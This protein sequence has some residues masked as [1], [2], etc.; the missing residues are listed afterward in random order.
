MRRILHI[1][2]LLSLVFVSCKKEPI[3]ELVDEQNGIETSSPKF[4]LKGLLGTDSVNI[5]SKGDYYMFS[6]YDFDVTNNH[7]V[8][9]GELKQTNCTSCGIGVTIK[10]N[11]YIASQA[12]A[13][14][15]DIDTVFKTGIKGWNDPLF[16]SNYL[17]KAEI[18]VNYNN[19]EPLRSSYS[20]SQ[21]N[22]SISI[23]GFSFF[24]DNELGKATV[25]VSFTGSVL[26]PTSS[27][28]SKLFT[29]EGVYAFAFPE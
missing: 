18:I 10:L 14:N 6:S 9:I 7:F 23:T 25:K 1:L 27:P 5:E 28:S 17:D 24:E 15:F 22:K 2:L 11:N 20:I 26:I 4:Y 8:F 21:V 3:P 16:P 13:I 29:F 12:Q 19:G